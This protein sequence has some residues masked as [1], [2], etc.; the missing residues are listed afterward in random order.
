MKVI[1]VAEAAQRV[2]EIASVLREGGLACFPV[3]GV[4]RIT[5]DARSEHA[6]QRLGQS[7]RRAKNHPALVLIE[8]LAAAREIV[9][10]TTWSTTRRLAERLWPRPL[11][12]VL[13]PS[14]ALPAKVRKILTR[15]TGKL[16]IRVPDDALASAV[17]R[18]FG[19][20]LLLS[21]A[22]LEQKPGA[23]SAATIRQRFAG[24]IDVWVDAGDV[25]PGPPST[26]VEVTEE[27]W[28]VVRDGSISLAD[29]ERAAA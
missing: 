29:L 22:N 15:A 5:V 21:S 14:N 17:L 8:D 28:K 4:Y 13:P 20:P 11:T 25:Q 18:A 26:I 23:S 27:A 2:G 1:P 10:G 6:I 24:T 9:D 7:K 19:G 16:G 12:L 3:R